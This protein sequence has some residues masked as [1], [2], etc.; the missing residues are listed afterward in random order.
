MLGSVGN[1]DRLPS[2]GKG[3]RVT[4]RDPHGHHRLATGKPLDLRG[5]VTG[6]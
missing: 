4:P 1:L 6:D 3:K 2:G 5:P